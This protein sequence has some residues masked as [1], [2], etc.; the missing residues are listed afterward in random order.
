LE[1]VVAPADLE[2]TRPYNQRWNWVQFA[3]TFFFV[4][5]VAFLHIDPAL[6]GPGIHLLETLLIA[7]ACASLAGRFGDSAWRGI[8]A[9]LLSL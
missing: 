4:G 9:F 1:K 5:F 8:I 7:S 6:G 3:C 2:T